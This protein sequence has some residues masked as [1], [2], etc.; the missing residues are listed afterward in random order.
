MLRLERKAGARTSSMT[1][2]AR[3]D[4]TM[5]LGGESR[6]ES[7]VV[8]CERGKVN[9]GASTRTTGDEDGV[10]LRVGAM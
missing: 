4:P 10:S 3:K 6:T 9:G 5:A 1:A 8:A 2:L 7:F